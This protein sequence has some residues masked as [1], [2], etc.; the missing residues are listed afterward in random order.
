[1]TG[2]DNNTPLILHIINREG[3][4]VGLDQNKLSSR[5]FVK[6]TNPSKFR[7]HF[8]LRGTLSPLNAVLSTGNYV[9]DS[10]L[11]IIGFFFNPISVGLIFDKFHR[12]PPP[13]KI[14]P[15]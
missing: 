15:N 8:Y 12:M 1:M 7:N 2:D 14:S 9:F 5:V 6:V 3:G 11:A 10:H 13:C 4:R